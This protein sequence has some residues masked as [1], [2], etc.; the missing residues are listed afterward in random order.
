VSPSRFTVRG[1]SIPRNKL[2]ITH[3]AKLYAGRFDLPSTRSIVLVSPPRY[4]VP[5]K[6]WAALPS[7]GAYKPAPWWTAYT[8][9]KHNRI[10]EITQATLDS[11]VQSLCGLHQV[12]ARLPEFAR[13]SMRHGWLQPGMK[14]SVEY[15]VEELE[16]G[17]LTRATHLVETK[18]FATPVGRPDQFPANLSDFH[19]MNYVCSARLLRFFGRH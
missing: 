1:K 11:A 8:K 14:W 17:G 19:T 15:V 4:V 16:K 13:A 12:I 2:D 7:G 9:M 5:F 6:E 18:L 10:A 3:F